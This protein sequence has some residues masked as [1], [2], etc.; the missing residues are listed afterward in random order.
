MCYARKSLIVPSLTWR[1]SSTPTPCG[2]LDAAV[3]PHPQR[4]RRTGC[5][6]RP[7]S[8]VPAQASVLGVHL[9]SPP[10]LALWVERS[11]TRRNPFHPSAQIENGVSIDPGAVI[12]PR[13]AFV[14]LVDFVL[15]SFIYAGVRGL[16]V[17]VICPPGLSQDNVEFERPGALAVKNIHRSTFTT[18]WGPNS[19]SPHARGR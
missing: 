13:A 7:Q 2:R 14:R 15:D 9:G 10:V 5:G 12:G 4:I 16:P 8:A 17:L 11:D 3:G 19:S 18:L 1:G 6:L